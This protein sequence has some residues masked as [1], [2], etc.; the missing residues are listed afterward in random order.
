MSAE[1]IEHL[2]LPA[3]A[4]ERPDRLG[5]SAVLD[6]GGAR[7]A[8]STDSFVVRPL[9]FPGGSIGDLAVNGTVNDLAMSGARPAYLSAGFILEEGT[10]VAVVGV[11]PTG[12]APRHGRPASRSS[13]ATPRSSTPATATGSSSTRPA[14]AWCPR[15]ARRAGPRR[16]RRRGHRQRRHRRPRRGDHERARGPG[17]RHR[18]PQRLR[19]PRRPGRGDAGGDAA[20]CTPCATPPAAGWR[21]ALNEIASASG[22]GVELDERPDPGARDGAERLRVA[23][24]RPV[25]RRQRGRAGRLR[26]AGP[27]RGGARRDAGAPVRR[28]RGR[29]RHAASRIIPAWWWHAPGS[30]PP[31]SSTCRSASSCR[32]SA[33]GD[34]VPRAVEIDWDCCPRRWSGHRP[35]AGVRH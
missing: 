12:S 29:D 18:D 28:G 24:A 32:G 25:V 22:V 3:L 13:P 26:A 8:F 16:A 17:V 6:L 10:E 9:F 34:E 27:G 11:S 2:F 19:A 1:L 21:T 14:S 31:A 5:D 23:R 35:D 30:A 33:D 15:G 7:V 20:T 4:N